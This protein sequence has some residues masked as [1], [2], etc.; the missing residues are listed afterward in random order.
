[1]NAALESVGPVPPEPIRVLYDATGVFPGGF[2]FP[3]RVANQQLSR[4]NAACTTPSCPLHPWNLD[5][6]LHHRVTQYWLPNPSG[7]AHDPPT[8]DLHGLL[9]GPI[10]DA[11]RYGAL[12]HVC[13]TL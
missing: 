12:R 1:M 5:A 7:A 11:G 6:A 2:L 4:N 9:R 8:G 10:G 13:V 3:A